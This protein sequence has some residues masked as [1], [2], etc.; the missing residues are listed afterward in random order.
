MRGEQLSACGDG[1]PGVGGVGTSRGSG[2][3]V[4][5]TRVYVY[6][7]E[8]DCEWISKYCD[9]HHLRG[10]LISAED[11][12]RLTTSSAAPEATDV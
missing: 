1:E 6:W 3:G 4:P 12:A 11:L 2:V 7:Y 8:H 5:E 9:E 10:A